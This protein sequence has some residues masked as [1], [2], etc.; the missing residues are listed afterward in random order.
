MPDWTPDPARV[1]RRLADYERR[2]YQRKRAGD[3][4]PFTD[5]AP[6]RDHLQALREAGVTQDQVGA[7]AGVS[8][9]TLIRAAKQTRMTSAAAAAIMAIP[10]PGLD[11]D[12]DRQQPPGAA[13][14]TAGEKLQTLVA[15]GWTLVQIAQATG[16]SER[17]IYQQ[18]HQQ[19]PP[20]RTTAEA[21]DRVYD[22]LVVDDPGDGYIAAR[23]RLRAERAGWQSST[24][25]QPPEADI[26][27]VAVDRVVAGDRLPLRP[28]EQHSVLTRLAGSYPDDEIARR[29]GLS[30]RTV[31]R[32]RSQNQLP[33]YT[34]HLRQ[35]DT[36]GR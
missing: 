10:I 5:T 11:P 19:V 12:V 24:P 27:N 17:A 35:P 30:T 28:A 3:W 29:L 34:G 22:Q 15:D 36:P 31:L 25:P 33:A 6:V 16:L 7:A 26:D 1:A 20:A 2:R 8:V 13:V 18:V 9:A 23:A 14:M 21:I 4:A 32:H